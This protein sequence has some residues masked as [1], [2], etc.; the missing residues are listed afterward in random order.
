MVWVVY[1]LLNPIVDS[2]R[3]IFSKKAS[4]NIDPILISLANNGIPM[5]LS[6]PLVFFI[7]FRFNTEFIIALIISS[8]INI[9][10][11]LLYHR[12]LSKGELSEVVPMLSFTPL[13]LLLSSPLLVGEFPS[14]YGL[15]GILLL[16]AG[17]YLLN[18][19]NIKRGILNPFRSLLKNKGTRYMLIVA[20]IWSISANFDKIAIANSSIL[21]YLFSVNLLVTAGISIF[22]LIKKKFDIEQIKLE[23]V[24]LLL[25]GLLTTAGFY[26]HM[27]AL[28][29]TLVAYVIAFK[30]M[31]GMISVVYGKIFMG[32]RNIRQRF[33]GALLMFMGVLFIL[34]F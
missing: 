17:S 26:V 24:N 29:M 12:A 16:V 10:A 5:L 23:K 30:R 3:N 8:L 18:I 2:T 14:F 20:F 1:A 9:A 21:Q 25:V 22:V 11:V 28:S 4:R 6:F 32:E 13:F 19:N 33:L 34:L 27:T 31:G 7:E 15:I